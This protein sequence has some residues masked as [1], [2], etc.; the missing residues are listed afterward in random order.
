MTATEDATLADKIAFLAR[1]QS[2]AHEVD[3]MIRK[4][5]QMSWVF[6]VGDRVYKLKKPV[7]FSYLDFATLARR[8]AACRAQVDLNRRLA[9]DVYVGVISLAVSKDAL[10]LGGEGRVV[11]WLVVMRRLDERWSLERAVRDGRLEVPQLD[12]LIATL[13]Q[14]YRCARPVLLA[15]HVRLAAWPTNLA[16]NRR[17]LLHRRFDLPAGLI[18][19]I[20]RSLQRF[21]VEQ[22]LAGSTGTWSAHS[23]WPWRPAPRAHLDHRIR[24]IDCLEFNLACGRW[25]LW[26]KS[27][28]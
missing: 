1:P 24:I 20:N 9:P 18:R 25:T 21:V 27:P 6:L 10:S 15:P 4:E 8:E 5:T 14:F 22:S 16:A 11:D 13:V 26:M 3:P 23:G 2:Y 12:R 17:V 28:F 7:R 19:R